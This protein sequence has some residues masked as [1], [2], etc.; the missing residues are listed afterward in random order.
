MSLLRHGLLLGAFAGLAALFGEIVAQLP[1]A[2][3]A[4]L[5]LR[6]API[7]AL[8][9][10][11]LGAAAALLAPLLSSRAARERGPGILLLG[12]IAA[13]AILAGTF[14][15]PLLSDKGLPRLAPAILGV[16]LAA[17][18]H[19][20]G[21][22]AA[23]SASA[24][25]VECFVSAFGATAG[26]C[27]LLLP[28]ALGALL[29]PGREPGATQ[30]ARGADRPLNVVLVVLEGVR[31]DHLGCL[32]SF[33]AASPRF[34]ALAGESVLF[35]RAFAASP[36][37]EESLA[38]LLGDPAAPLAPDLAAAGWQTWSVAAGPT[39]PPGFDRR[40]DVLDGSLPER[41]LLVRWFDRARARFTV[42][43]PSRP[44]DRVVERALA[45]A[46][47][48]DPARPFFLLARLSDTAPP[49]D[50]PAELRDRF[51]PDSL[52]SADLQ[53]EVRDQD[54]LRLALLEQG[55]LTASPQE[56]QAF[57]A[58]YDA[59]ILAQDAALGALVDGLL[60]LGLLEDALLVVVSDHGVRFGEEGGLL[61]S[62]G[63]L[64]DAVLR[65]PILLRLPRLLPA[66]TRALGL[67]SLDDVAPAIR[68]VIAGSTEAPLLAAA[69]GGSPRRSVSATLREK[70][71]VLRMLR[72]EREK[73]LLDAQGEVIA[74]GDLLA[75]PDESFLRLRPPIDPLSAAR[76]RARAA[77]LSDES[78]AG[79][80]RDGEAGGND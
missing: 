72:G 75:D 37:H 69:Q 60:H 5:A 18:A 22:A 40:V 25:R 17:G 4:G 67:V 27:L 53:R 42:I 45:L 65:V 64:H 68:A 74:A 34:D 19:L 70:G 12:T 47:T 38:R 3:E 79:P 6:W 52:S 20:L 51:L 54:A 32:G 39:T 62:A 10:A 31:A 7:Y 55:T 2:E 48:R 26:L 11:A 71:A 41:L 73:I 13:W 33:R 43:S 63:S 49:Y 78:A 46:A 29:L 14:L 35:E 61:G 56:A 28:A 36:D 24:W 66:G 50:P 76:W 16:G 15:A 23:G 9:G 44:A 58:L 80:G 77:E 30:A 59:E 8:A 1:A 21:L 57:A